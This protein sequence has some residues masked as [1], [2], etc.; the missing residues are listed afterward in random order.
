MWT[1]PLSAPK[2]SV[3]PATCPNVFWRRP[4]VRPAAAPPQIRSEFTERFAYFP[5]SH[6]IA[7]HATRY[8]HVPRVTESAHPWAAAG[9]DALRR[10]VRP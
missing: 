1:R 8:P 3:N 4:T 9:S 5:H 6:F 7:A 2:P 10:K